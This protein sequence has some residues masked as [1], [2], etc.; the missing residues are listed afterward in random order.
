MKRAKLSSPRTAIQ[1]RVASFLLA[2]TFCFLGSAAQ[3]EPA[4]RQ[5]EQTRS[6]KRSQAANQQ[7]D[8]AVRINVNKAQQGTAVGNS[9]QVRARRLRLFK[10]NRPIASTPEQPKTQ[11][12]KGL[13]ISRSET[14][15]RLL[16]NTQEEETVEI[17]L[18][19]GI[20]R[21]Q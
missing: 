8:F 10:K 11:E 17:L 20:K 12:K 13:S 16:L 19:Q 2:G 7:R 18:P 1:T 4:A 6:I 9:R 5:A 15:L 21:R 3:A 14:G